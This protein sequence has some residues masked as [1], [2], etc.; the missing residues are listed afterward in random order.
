[1]TTASFRGILRLGHYAA[2]LGIILAFVGL[3]GYLTTAKPSTGPITRGLADNI[4]L[5]KGR[6]WDIWYSFSNSS[7]LLNQTLDVSFIVGSGGVV[8][9]YIMSNSQYQNWKNGSVATGVLVETGR[10][11][12]NSSF[13]PTAYGKYYLVLDNTPYNTSKSI[14]YR[15]TWIA[16][17]ALVDY[18]ESFDWLF[19]S[20]A[21][22]SVSITLNLLTGNPINTSLKRLLEYACPKR[23]KKIRGTEDIRTRTNNSLKL[24][25]IYV[26][27]VAALIIATLIF[28]LI[29]NISFLQDFPEMTP[30]TVDVMVRLSVYYSLAFAFMGTL[31]L[32]FQWLSGFLD[33]VQVWYL[34]DRKGLHWNKELNQESYSI[35]KR[36]LLSR[37]SVLCYALFTV[38]FAAAFLV[39]NLRFPLLAV[40]VL[41]A[42]VPVSRAVSLSF[43]GACKTLKL[44]WRTELKR[45]RPFT[46]NGVLISILLIPV[47][48]SALA[49]ILPPMFSVLD[50]VAIN[51]FAGPRF[52]QY[53]YAEINPREQLSEILGPITGDAVI[54]SSLLFLM[55]LAAAEY[56]MPRIAKELTTKRKLR[57]LATPTIAFLMAFV[58]CEAYTRYVEAAYTSRPELSIFV[59]LVAFAVSYLAGMAYEE[60]TLPGK[61]SRRSTKTPSSRSST[62]AEQV[63]Q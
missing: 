56:I 25:W 15:Y 24:F 16:K 53:F 34:V 17:A 55:I 63:K 49:W 36:M 51:S 32:F 54:L 10:N 19:L 8:D 45:S 4:T 29:K 52:Q 18:S 43:R 12:E 20:I 13:V 3:A 50:S 21:G 14:A 7:V 6:S 11:F 44:K 26:T 22:I 62:E 9:F 59:S 33:D 48:L 41:V 5:Q 2:L 61:N 39:P 35:M 23:A 27:A 28:M 58:T 38:I 60:A 1:V 31:L 47:V 46:I 57:R 42:S 37:G 40:G 30:M